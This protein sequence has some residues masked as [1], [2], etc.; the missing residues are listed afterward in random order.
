MATKHIYELPLGG[1]GWRACPAA[2]DGDG[3]TDPAV[4]GNGVWGAALSS[5]GYAVAPLELGA[6]GS[7]PVPADYDGDGKADPAVYRESDGQWTVALSSQGYAVQTAEFGASGF[8]PVPADYDGDGKA[9][10]A[11]YSRSLGLWAVALSGSGYAIQ[12]QAFNVP[13]ATPVPGD[14]DGDGKTDYAIYHDASGLWL[15]YLSGSG[16]ALSYH[17]L[18]GGDYV[19]VAGRFYH[20]RRHTF[21]VYRPSTGEW[22]IWYPALVGGEEGSEGGPFGIILSTLTE[23]VG[24][25]AM[26]GAIGWV[27]DLLTHKDSGSQEQMQQMSQQLN[28]MDLQM[29]TLLAMTANLSTQLDD[30]STQLQLDTTETLAY[31]QGQTAQAAINTITTHYDQDGPDSMQTFFTSTNISATVISNFA[32]N[33]DNGN[34]PIQESVTAIHNALMPGGFGEQGLLWGWTTNFIL[35]AA[36]ADS[37]PDY[38]LTLED[39]YAYLYSYLMKGASTYVEA[40][41]LLYSNDFGYVTGTLAPFINAE[42]DQF[43]QCTYKMMLSKA[44]FVNN[45]ANNPT[46]VPTVAATNILFRNMFMAAQARG[47]N[48]YG[49]N[50]FILATMD[51]V[52]NG[53]PQISA[54]YGYAGPFYPVTSRW[55]SVIGPTYDCWGI[56]RMHATNQYAFLQYE[57]GTNQY[58]QALPTGLYTF[59]PFLIA[60]TTMLGKYDASLNANPTGNLYGCYVVQLRNGGP[61]PFYEAAAFY[62]NGGP[63]FSSTSSVTQVLGDTT[64]QGAIMNTTVQ[65]YA[66]GTNPAVV[67]VVITNGP[68][69]SKHAN[70][71]QGAITV[72]AQALWTFTYDGQ[73]PANGTLQYQAASSGSF[74]CTP[75]N[76]TLDSQYVEYQNDSFVAK[77]DVFDKTT[78]GVCA[79]CVVKSFAVTNQRYNK[80]TT[81]NLGANAQGPLAV[82][83]QPGHVYQVRAGWACSLMDTDNYAG[84][85]LLY[86]Y[87]LNV[88]LVVQGLAFTFE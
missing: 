57:F 81:I 84:P 85:V 64:H 68:L 54:F 38:Y 10:P 48:A 26:D 77:I 37:L 51:A 66:A 56:G 33:V 44:D 34:Y 78:N 55:V 74:I 86:P 61:A 62:G 49:L 28:S 52:T 19:P 63:M 2:Y 6:S 13:D 24:T 30:L 7:M 14:Y 17:L 5:R 45:F 40:E 8:A 20:T 65:Q 67:S 75:P 35:S 43:E 73:T 76:S 36:T 22:R 16:Y 39:Y 9:D 47:T 46:F 21:G 82:P 70:N 32:N 72:N 79:S 23:G 1:P 69:D 83:F 42:V 15:G 41:H 4:Y 3:K 18:G 12:T 60:G 59:S 53:M 71:K 27:L 80:T 29:V 31:I 25:W 88:S 87:Y 58:G 50:A 11:V